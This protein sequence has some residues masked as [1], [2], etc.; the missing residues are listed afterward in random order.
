MTN[1]VGLRDQALRLY[2][3]RDIGTD[4]YTKKAYVFTAWWW[5]RLEETRAA[6]HASEQRLQM[7]LDAVA[8]FAHEAVVPDKGVLV[9]P[10]GT[11]WWIR[12]FN[13]N[14]LLRRMIVGLDRITEEQVTTV[15][16]FEMSSNLVGVQ[17]VDPSA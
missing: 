12:G 6:V 5:G 14:R 15:T 11:M 17:V 10:D 16:L 2:A 4:G 1:A 9:D 8:E 3:R 7:K 13:S